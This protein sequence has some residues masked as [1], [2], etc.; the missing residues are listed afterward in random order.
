MGNNKRTAYDWF[1]YRKD[2]DFADKPTMDKAEKLAKWIN[3]HDLYRPCDAYEVYEWLYE[4]YLDDLQE[5]F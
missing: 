5:V 4:E 2:Y 3:S 1:I